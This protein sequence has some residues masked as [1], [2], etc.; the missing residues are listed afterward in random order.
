[1][2]T[3][4]IIFISLYHTIVIAMFR[5]IFTVITTNGV[6]D[7]AVGDIRVGK[8]IF[9]TIYATLFITLCGV[10]FV[11]EIEMYDKVFVATSST[12]IF[13]VIQCDHSCI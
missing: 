8:T 5:I 4:N 7:T 2:F 9:I 11:V 3:M 13:D 12:M 6:I 1:M 10:V